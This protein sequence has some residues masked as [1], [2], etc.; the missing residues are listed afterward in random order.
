MH[1]TRII[2]WICF[3]H[4]GSMRGVLLNQGNYADNVRYK[5]QNGQFVANGNAIKL[6]RSTSLIMQSFL[7]VHK[8]VMI[9]HL[10]LGLTSQ[11]CLDI[12]LVIFE[13][14]IF[15]Q[16]L[17]RHWI[18]SSIIVLVMCANIISAIMPE[19]ILQRTL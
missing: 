14:H 17:T 6:N 10:V 19:Y 15:Q 16:Q 5:Y 9:W 1:L 12:K 2:F 11:H 4:Y 18:F 8:I 3:C 13:L 7:I